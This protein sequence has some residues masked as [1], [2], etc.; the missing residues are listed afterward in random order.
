[1]T[2]AH[3]T[4]PPPPAPHPGP[5]QN[6]RVGI[7]AMVTG[8]VALALAFIPLIVVSFALGLIA[9]GLGFFAV[10]KGKGKRQ[11][12][13]GMITGA[14]A[15]VLVL[16]GLGQQD[17][18]EK[19][20]RELDEA[21]QNSLEDAQHG[22]L[23]EIPQA[24]SALTVI[25]DQEALPEGPVG[26]VAVVAISEPDNSAFDF[27]I[28][29]RT[30]HAVSRVEVRGTAIGPDEETLGT[31]SSGPVY[32]NVILPGDYGFGYVYVDRF[33]RTFPAGVSLPDLRVG[34]TRGLDRRESIISVDIEDFEELP[35]GDLT[36]EVV[37]PHASTVRGPIGIDTVC[38]TNDDRVFHYNAYSD[39]DTV[40]AG[41]S[42]TWTLSSRG[43]EPQCV[44]RLLSAQ[45]YK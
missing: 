41:D 2:N 27:I 39:N 22:A 4:P 34:Y 33:E 30:D 45:G 10:I 28:H 6:K 14:V 16:I 9:I 23:P 42:S 15:I 38:L 21:I 31:G 24:Y 32:P 29:N 36:G 44:V 18:P 3:P 11:G 40:D 12:I 8:I 19:L 1:M 5:T 35:S 20:Q 25:G 26:E 13:A 17:D 37:N 43:D 7:A